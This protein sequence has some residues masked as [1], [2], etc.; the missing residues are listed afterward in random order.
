MSTSAAPS[1]GR[2]S[3]LGSLRHLTSYSRLMIGGSMIG[4]IVLLAIFGPTVWP[5]SATELSG[6]PLQGISWDHP[7]GTDELG[8]DELARIL[9]GARVSLAVAAVAVSI[10]LIGGIVIGV[11]AGHLGNRVDTI[12]MR[13]M[14]GLQAFPA[15]LL[16]IMI[17][18]ALG[19]GLTQV[20]IA[21]GIAII[22]GFARLARSQALRIRHENYIDA[23]RLGGSREVSIIFRHVVPNSIS[24]MIVFAATTTAQVIL[25]EAALAF[26]G[27][28]A[29]PPT[30]DWGAMLAS[31]YAYL[32]DAPGLTIFPGGAIA[33][34]TLAFVFLGDGLR[35]WLDPRSAAN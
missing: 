10:G 20:M 24:P 18:A 2:R 9:L 3:F 32:S 5:E 14:D 31:G 7:M 29:A 30:P 25:V 28:G 1:L 27:L 21:V 11:L 35:D 16:A 15:L 26:L 6:L 13:I 23:A 22:P 12:L 33:I 8:R 34:T 4:L 17:A 19:A